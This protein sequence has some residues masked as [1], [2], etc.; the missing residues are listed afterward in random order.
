MKLFRKIKSDTKKYI[1]L[2]FIFFIAIGAIILG[3]EPIKWVE[4]KLSYTQTV[5]QEV[6]DNIEK[7]TT[8][9]AEKM[10][11]VEETNLTLQRA[12]I[13]YEEADSLNTH[14]VEELNGAVDSLNLYRGITQ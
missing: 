6:V 5:E 7:L 11:K 2:G 8:N 9:L 1:F 14:A 3:D 13:A 10:R 4:Q 12:K